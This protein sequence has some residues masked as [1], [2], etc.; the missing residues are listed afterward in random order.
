MM[1]NAK[2]QKGFS[3]FI[4]VII[5]S[6]LT[7]VAF[8]VSKIVTRG[9]EFANTGRASQ[10]AFFASDAGIECA[11]YWDT[12]E[13]SKFATSTS[14][15]PITCA[16]VSMSGN[17]LAGSDAILGTSTLTRIGGGG[18]GNP[19]SVFGFVLNQGSNSSN[20]CVIVFVNK[21]YSGSNLITKISSYGYNNCNTND[22]R[23]VERGLEV[24]Y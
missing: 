12:Q 7:L 17:G 5:A 21:S 8:T 11:I 14:G 23:R 1:K 10:E 18:A 22:P 24:T 15:S 13:P 16:G 9:I 19:T 20:A 3:L 4:A 2:N 6:A